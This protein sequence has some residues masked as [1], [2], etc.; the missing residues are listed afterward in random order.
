MIYEI[1][2]PSDP[3]T[4]EADEPSVACAACLLLSPAFGLRSQDDSVN[5]P[6]AR[7][8][9]YQEWFEEHFHANV[10]K[11]IKSHLLEIVAVLDSVLIGEAQDRIDFYEALKLTDDPAK[12]QQWR[13]QYL[14]RRRSSMNNIGGEAMRMADGI[15]ASVAKAATEQEDGK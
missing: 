13:E 15:R 10:D 5:M 11:F 1:I 9:G 8:A 12:K 4:L 7:F 14:A 6:P 2:N 3:Y